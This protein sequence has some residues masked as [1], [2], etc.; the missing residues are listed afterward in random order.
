MT[1]DVSYMKARPI[2]AKRSILITWREV[3]GIS[4]AKLMIL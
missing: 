4:T 3:F 2:Y 1:D